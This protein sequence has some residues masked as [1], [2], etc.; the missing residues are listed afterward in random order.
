MFLMW[1]NVSVCIIFTNSIEPINSS[2]TLIL[3][4]NDADGGLSCMCAIFNNLLWI[5]NLYFI[6]VL[7]FTLPYALAVGNWIISSV[8]NLLDKLDTF[9]FHK[10]KWTQGSL[11]Q[12]NTLIMLPK[13]LWCSEGTS[14]Y[15]G[16]P[17]DPELGN[18]G[19]NYIIYTIST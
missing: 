11:L 14:H 16:E 15:V 12:W 9:G 5:I 2:Q 1:L 7:Y 3:K 13:A 6:F 4:L 18:G 17:R 10:H 8:L 19:W